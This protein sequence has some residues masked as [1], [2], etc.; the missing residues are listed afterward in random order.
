MDS[1]SPSSN[2]GNLRFQRADFP[3]TEEFPTQYLTGG[4]HPVSVGDVYGSNYKVLRKLGCG[5]Y[6]TVWLAEDLRFLPPC[7]TDVRNGQAVALKV[8]A[9]NASRRELDI[10]K[11]LRETFSSFPMRQVCG[12]NAGSFR[13]Y[14]PQR[15]P[16]LHCD[17]ADVARRAGIPGGL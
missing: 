1:D 10:M 16:S 7:S 5:A 11:R 3:R 2:I 6:S 13:A 15:E 8:L 14:R 9:D 17:G 4:F 12:A